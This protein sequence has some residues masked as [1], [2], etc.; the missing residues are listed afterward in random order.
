[1]S[2]A[3][4]CAPTRKVGAWRLNVICTL[5]TQHKCLHRCHEGVL[6]LA[7]PQ[8]SA[9]TLCN[10]QLSSSAND[11]SRP[12]NGSMKSFRWQPPAPT[13]P[14]GAP[15]QRRY[16]AVLPAACVLPAGAS[17]ENMSP[18]A[19]GAA[20]HTRRRY[21]ALLLAACVLQAGTSRSLLVRMLK[22]ITKSALK[23]IKGYLR[24]S[25]GWAQ[26]LGRRAAH[27]GKRSPL[28]ACSTV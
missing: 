1:M 4:A 27:C 18:P 10:S 15:A 3:P 26:R 24:H 2:M 8:L 5:I 17:L 19:T 23:L 25:S 13:S 12:S 16:S 9:N 6:R 21:S 22:H 20:P 14:K 11:T 28:R 7:H